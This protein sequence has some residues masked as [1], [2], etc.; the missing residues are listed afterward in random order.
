[1]A[2]CEVLGL[3]AETFVHTGS[4]QSAGAIDLPVMRERTTDYPFIPGSSIKGALRDALG[5]AAAAGD[6]DRLFGTQDGAGQLLIGDARLLLL[7]VRSLSAPYRWVTCPLLL[8][9]LDRDLRRAGADGI[10]MPSD[11]VV[12]EG[13]A[14][15]EEGTGDL[16]LEERQFAIS[17]KLPADLANALGALIPNAKARGRLARQLVVLHD[18]DFAWFA[19]YALPVHA[20]NVLDDKTKASKNLWYE[21]VLPPDTVLWLVL[22]DRGSSDAAGTLADNLGNYL[23]VGGNETVGQG[24]FAVGRLE[25]GAATGTETR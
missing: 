5:G 12:S 18:N 6:V 10:A 11:P 16:Y 17:G 15:A 14:L 8:E 2:K 20:R 7:P 25:P 19:Q 24:W 23:Q 21:E 22:G 9:R 4:G 13:E 3:L 1:M